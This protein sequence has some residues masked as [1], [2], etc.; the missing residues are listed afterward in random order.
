MNAVI[1]KLFKKLYTTS[2]PQ[3]HNDVVFNQSFQYAYDFFQSGSGT[4]LIKLLTNKKHKSYIIMDFWNIVLR[5]QFHKELH[6]IK[7]FNKSSSIPKLSKSVD[8]TTYM[9]DIYDF[10]GYMAKRFPQLTFVLVS[11]STD[12]SKNRYRKLHKNIVEIHTYKPT[13]YETDDIVIIMCAIILEMRRIENYCLMTRDYYNWTDPSMEIY[14]KQCTILLTKNKN[15]KV[16]DIV[17]K[18]IANKKK[19]HPH[20]ITC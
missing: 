4:K 20:R 10:V 19:C 8:I 7:S 6:Q 5:P 17:H 13:K 14:K 12:D 9:H 15:K 11:G 2:D 16:F 1:N 3:K 18:D